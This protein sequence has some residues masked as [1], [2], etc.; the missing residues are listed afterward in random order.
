MKEYLLKYYA[1]TCQYYGT[2]HN[3]KEISAWAGLALHV[4][5]CG[6]I[7]TRTDIPANLWLSTTL[8]L[9]VA[10]ILVAFFAFRYIWNQ[11]EMKDRAGALAGAA[12]FLLVEI[13]RTEESKLNPDDYL[14]VVESADTKAQSSHVLPDR[15]LKKADVL[16]TR[17]RGFQDRTRWMIYILLALSTIS[18]IGLKWI[19]VI[20]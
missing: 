17:G 14:L 20:A 5:F 6:L 8:A 2:Y 11:L 12:G 3:H 16:N 1:D 18:V 19:V 4:L 15:L 13:L 7:I 9:T 10:V